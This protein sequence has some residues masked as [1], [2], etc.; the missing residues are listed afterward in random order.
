MEWVF[1]HLQM[2]SDINIILKIYSGPY[3]YKFYDFS[4]LHPTIVRGDV[5]NIRHAPGSGY[6]HRSVIN[7]DLMAVSHFLYTD[8]STNPFL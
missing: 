2:L 6:L 4:R 7:F 8:T 3:H 1:E 5:F